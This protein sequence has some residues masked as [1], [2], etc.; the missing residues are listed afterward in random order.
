MSA[1]CATLCYPAIVHFIAGLR[2]PAIRP[3]LGKQAVCQ[4]EVST[5]L[6]YELQATMVESVF[7]A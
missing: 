5:D 2:W 7:D 6:R 4:N 1:P 3:H